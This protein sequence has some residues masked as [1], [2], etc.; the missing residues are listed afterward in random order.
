VHGPRYQVTDMDGPQLSFV[1]VACSLFQALFDLCATALF[2]F[3]V[4]I[5]MDYTREGNLRM[6]AKTL[7]LP[8]SMFT[9]VVLYKFIRAFALRILR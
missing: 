2:C 6:L 8:M 3:D 9:W 1:R 5:H 4:N 7:T